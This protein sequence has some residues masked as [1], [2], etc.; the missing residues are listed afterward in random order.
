MKFIFRVNHA[1]YFKVARNISVLALFAMVLS[2]SDVPAREKFPGGHGQTTSAQQIETQRAVL[3][4]FDPLNNPISGSRTGGGESAASPAV[5][6]EPE[7]PE[8]QISGVIK[9]GRQV[10]LKE[11]MMFFIS[12]RP[13]GGGPPIAAQRM[14][15]PEFP[16]KFVL[17]AKDAMIA[18]TPFEGELEITARL[19]QDGDP[20]TRQ[21]GD[22]FGVQK[23]IVGASGVEIVM[24]QAAQ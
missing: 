22:F 21:E 9:L 19:D 16:Y 14:F 7:L 12:A 13:A 3:G 1:N 5:A 17:S 23:A 2:C 15:R 10:R 11:R 20:I 6:T 4:G 18:G 8:N 24:D